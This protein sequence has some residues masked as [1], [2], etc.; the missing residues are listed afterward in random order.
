MAAMYKRRNN[1]Q[2]HNIL[3]GNQGAA[4]HI[5]QAL[6]REDVIRK[7]DQ[8]RVLLANMRSEVRVENLRYLREQQQ[9]RN[10]DNMERSIQSEKEKR[11]AHRKQLEIDE[12]LTKQLETE[13]NQQIREAK[14]R[15]HI[16]ENSPELR[17]LELKLKA[18]YMN[19]E[20]VAQVEES[21]R[22]AEAERAKELKFL[23]TRD[24]VLMEQ[25]EAERK[26]QEEN[27][28]QALET[29]RELEQQLAE[30]E[31]QKQ[32]D[33]QE[34]LKEKLMID[35]I[36]RTIH[37]EDE[38]MQRDRR[39]QQEETRHYIQEY[40]KSRAAWKKEADEEAARKELEISQFGAERRLRDAARVAIKQKERTERD[41]VYQK[42]AAKLDTEDLEKRE[43]RRI[44][45]EL[46]FEEQQHNMRLD[47]EKR[48]RKN[49][50]QRQNLRSTQAEQL[51][52]RAEAL[53]KAKEDE[54][55][56]RKKM[57]E[58]FQEDERIQ[59][60]KVEQRK[61]KQIEFKQVVDRL[62]DERRHI[63]MAERRQEELE[64][65]KQLKEESYRQQLYEEEKRRLIK[66]H[67]AH[68]VDYLPK[69]VLRHED[70]D[71]LDGETKSR[72]LK[73]KEAP[74]DRKNSRAPGKTTLSLKEL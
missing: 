63:A 26:E 71:L 2:T 32:M 60:L 55:M 47:E 31:R 36:V 30:R 34:F 27:H 8:D 20:R 58:K 25:N 15:Q 9:R 74:R 65:Q 56:F 69:G 17:Q 41:L 45:D 28:K 70:L 42:L 12:K 21:R 18:A 54:E 24:K 22:H 48:M 11:E 35:D 59:L 66:E 72:F 29:R 53:R 49:Q 62:M 73:G 23:E 52:M 50:E 38:E 68:L 51:E 19:R 44:R 39:K 16:R 43:S 13:R 40:E 14:M 3:G 6:H 1:G 4:P 5:Q 46:Y 57:M 7:V 33:Y 10:E 61:Q 64:A 37:R 67:G